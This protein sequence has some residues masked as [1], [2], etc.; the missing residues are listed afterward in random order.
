MTTDVG[1]VRERLRGSPGVRA[2]AFGVAIALLL[3]VAALASREP[4]RGSRSARAAPISGSASQ[5][6]TLSPW[7]LALI[8]AGATV[9]LVGLIAYVGWPPR[10][11]IPEP[12][13][14]QPPFKA[15]LAV[16]I[17]AVLLPLMVSAVLVAGGLA[18]SRRR[19]VLIGGSGSAAPATVRAVPS[20]RLPTSTS[21]SFDLPTWV[22]VAV[23]ALVLAGVVALVAKLS[24]RRRVAPRDGLPAVPAV[25]VAIAASLEDLATDPD[26]RRAVIRAYRRMEESL[27][28]AGLP[29]GQA[30]APREYLV[31]AS[32]SLKVD[33]KPLD[34]LTALFE[35]A[36]FSLRNVDV[37][38][39]D[40]AITALST[41]QKEL[42]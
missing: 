6:V 11:R 19:M 5:G 38:L 31:R 29:R 16:R 25:N 15:P 14:T 30:E 9:A 26:R 13:H 1:S 41:L 32:A 36:K 18:G 33:R 3:C 4:L 24:G 20:V 28:A 23:L 7:G 17:G 39:R 2:L 22:P 40:E 42:A 27:A 21:S 35:R 10:R 12:F 34:T 8:A 37:P